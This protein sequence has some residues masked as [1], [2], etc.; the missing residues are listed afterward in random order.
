MSDSSFLS[1]SREGGQEK[2]HRLQRQGR[3][4]DSAFLEA[5][6]G[7]P[8]NGRERGLVAAQA[9][10]PS[11]VLVMLVLAILQRWLIPLSAVL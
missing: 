7:P 6:L 8:E 2:A 4:L 11:I 3:S 5:G 1:A 10:L 9:S